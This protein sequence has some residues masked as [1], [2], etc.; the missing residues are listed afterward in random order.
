MASSP[1]DY[2]VQAV[3]MDTVVVQL[4]GSCSACTYCYCTLEEPAEG[5]A[6]I[7]LVAHQRRI[8]LVQLNEPAQ[9][10]LGLGRLVLVACSKP[11]PAVAVACLERVIG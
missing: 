1:S 10:E 8:V 11:Q 6:D 9:N 5:L 4:D 7:D 3:E 2:M